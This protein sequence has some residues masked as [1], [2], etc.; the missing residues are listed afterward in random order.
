MANQRTDM[1]KVRELLRLKFEKNLSI[2]Q[3]SKAVGIGK[4]AG[5]EYIAGFRRSGLSL[6]DISILSDDELI[7]AI[8]PC[9]D[10]ENERYQYLSTRFSYFEKELKRTGVTLQLLWQEYRQQTVQGYGY[11]QFCHHFG[12]WQKSQ[13]VSM[14]ITHKA[15]DKM[16]VD[17]TGSKV[18]VADPITGELTQCEVFVA[19]L[20]ASQYAY[21]EAVPSQKV[22]DW[23]AA[24]ENAL[25][26]FGGVPRAIVPDCLKSAVIKADKYEPILNDTFRDF[27][28]HFDTAIVPARAL[29]PKD[30][31]L[32]ENFVRIAYQRIYA[33]LRNETFFNL[34]E[35]NE[36]FL[37]ELDKHNN[38][39][40]QKKDHSRTELFNEI[41]KNEL[42]A[43]PVARYDLKE[44]CKLKVQYNHHIYLKDDKHYYSVPFRFTGKM[45]TVKHGARVIEIYHNNK[46]IAL[47]QRN[48]AAYA[49][50]TKH[51]HRPATHQYVAG[52]S[53]ERFIRWGDQIAPETG[54]VIR[55]VL[56]SKQHPEQGYRSCMGILSLT[57]KYDKKDF[58]K[59]CKKALSVNC[60]TYRFIDNT[61][62]NQTFLMSTDE[63]LTKIPIHNNIRGKENYN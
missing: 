29:H 16:Y 25:Y 37:T 11:S 55:S 41:E 27:A 30:K 59:A 24:N 4:T 12:Q 48:R 40:F 62:K 28:H 49:Y 14:P 58:V 43:L 42:K 38:T 13:K 6:S 5:S 34:E 19:V 9:C 56:E 63:I 17:F 31:S 50:T 35:L 57:K 22:A 32:A 44:F 23:V 15:G 53:A 45:V 10:Q 21:I 18:T 52:W 36:A 46:R 7:L 51:D 60:L 20:G 2:R 39:P 1:R 8:S 33:P 47:H 26:Y 3:A 54:Q 61:L